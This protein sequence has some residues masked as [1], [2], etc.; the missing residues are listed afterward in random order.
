M[1]TPRGHADRPGDLMQH[2][3]RA[4]SRMRRG[5]VRPAKPSEEK[6]ESRRALLRLARTVV[7][8]ITGVPG[9]TRVA[10]VGSLATTKPNPKDVDLLVSV[11]PTADLAPLAHH[12]R[13][14]MGAAQSLGKG[15]DVFLATPGG[16]Y[17]GRV[18]QW[19]ICRFGVR[20]RCDALHCGQRPY[21]H[22]DLKTVHLSNTQ[23]MSPPVVLWPGIRC[24]VS[25][26]TDLER[27]L[28][29]WLRK[30]PATH[31]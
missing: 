14:L 7:P 31:P 11:E 28:L 2:E 9:V 13:R 4:L 17:L 23:I 30:P 22:D 20:L 15:A 25:V 18:C 5:T 29:R 19:K 16:N 8:D 1:R 26:P 6:G 21:L 3:T 27:G 24:D 12:A 10:L